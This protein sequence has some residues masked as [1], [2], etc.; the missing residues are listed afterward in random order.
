MKG[1]DLVNVSIEGLDELLKSLEKMESNAEDLSR[2]GLTIPA[3]ATEEEIKQI[4][5]EKLTKL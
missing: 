3:D 4:I 5:F 1:G 2:N